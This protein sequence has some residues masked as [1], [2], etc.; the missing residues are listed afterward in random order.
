MNLKDIPIGKR[1]MGAFT[2]FT[3][4]ILIACAISFVNMK[5]MESKAREIVDI[6]FQKASLA[7]TV[8]NNLQA[9]SAAVGVAVFTRDKSA[10]GVVGE[11]RKAYVEALEKL[12]KIETE[13]AGKDLI[14]K[15]KTDIAGGR[16]ANGKMMK[17]AN[18]DRF[19]EAVQLYTTVMVPAA[20]ANMVTV[21]E[22]V[23]FQEKGIQEKYKEIESTNSTAGTILIVFAVA[24]VILCIL[25]STMI[26]RSITAPIGRNIEIARTLAEWK[27]LCGCGRGQ[28]GR[29]RR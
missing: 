9:I 3:L 16:E 1:L 25:I 26:T 23:K 5:G 4:I 12:E 15:L 7:S 6:N 21:G 27:P 11:R 10:F 2:I 17:A 14:N 24:A 29:V 22:I 8:L 20:A 28:E 18:E 13:Q 19:E